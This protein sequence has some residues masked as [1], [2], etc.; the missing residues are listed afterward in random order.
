MPE[1]PNAIDPQFF[2]QIPV[3]RKWPARKQTPKDGGSDH[4][5]RVW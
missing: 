2:E 4:R 5:P 3:W 1:R